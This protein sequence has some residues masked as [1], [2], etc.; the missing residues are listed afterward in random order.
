[1]FKLQPIYTE[2]ELETEFAPSDK[3]RLFALDMQHICTEYGV[4]T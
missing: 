4:Q 3:V 2:W 1:V